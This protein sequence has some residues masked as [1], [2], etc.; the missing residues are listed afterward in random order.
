MIKDLWDR[1]SRSQRYIAIGGG[2]AL[3]VAIL[4]ELIVFPVQD[5]HKRAQSALRSNQRI[6][7]E[8]VPLSAE[9]RRLKQDLAQIEGL[10][11]ARPV[12]FN[13][14]SHV[15]RKTGEAAVKPLV[16]SMNPIRTAALVGPYEETAVDIKIE[17][18]TLKQLVSFLYLVES[19]AELVRVKSLTVT[20]SKEKAGYLNAALQV[21]AYERP[22]GETAPPVRR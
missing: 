2:I 11:A 14:F 17:T 3:L 7:K 4:L 9:Y 21:V 20:R 6:L 12:S 18:I 19:P 8:I 1:L 22:K 10:V 13:L 16:K 5:A 15:E